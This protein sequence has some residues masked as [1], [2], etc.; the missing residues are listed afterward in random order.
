[1]VTHKEH[2]DLL[3][4]ID[5]LLVSEG[6]NAGQWRAGTF[7]A[8]QL[9]LGAGMPNTENNWRYIAHVI[10]LHYP[11]SNWERGSHDEGIK[12]RVRIRI[13]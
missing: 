12:I 8:K 5:T 10:K 2:Q 4:T 1:M 7:T 6:E 11:D 13:K 9:L 3:T